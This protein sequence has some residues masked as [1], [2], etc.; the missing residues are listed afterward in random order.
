MTT[1]L[2]LHLVQQFEVPVPEPHAT[3]LTELLPTAGCSATA[4]AIEEYSFGPTQ[5]YLQQNGLFA[6]DGLAWLLDDR[7]LREVETGRS[8]HYVP[9]LLTHAPGFVHTRLEPIAGLTR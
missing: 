8:W 9:A 6:V 1:Q 4:R 3:R 7:Y 5:D 2:D